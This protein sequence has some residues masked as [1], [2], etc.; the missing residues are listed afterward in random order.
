MRRFKGKNLI[1]QCENF[2]VK[3]K[4]LRTGSCNEFNNHNQMNKGGIRENQGVRKLFFKQ[5]EVT[6]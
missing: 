4:F 5:G 6:K 1:C 2:N 3:R